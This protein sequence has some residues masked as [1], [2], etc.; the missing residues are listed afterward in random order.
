[1]QQLIIQSLSSLWTHADAHNHS[2]TQPPTLTYTHTRTW[3]ASQI[4]NKIQNAMQQFIRRFKIY[5]YISI[6]TH[7]QTNNFV[8]SHT[9]IYIYTHIYLHL[10]TM[11]VKSACDIYNLHNYYYDYDYIITTMIWLFCMYFHFDIAVLFSSFW[12][13]YS[14]Y[15]T[16]SV[17]VYLYSNVF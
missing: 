5:T 8:Y 13:R 6:H 14:I 16:V 1:M 12:T 2:H 3:R 9:H 11:Q 10:S 15:T 4:S 17:S 7:T